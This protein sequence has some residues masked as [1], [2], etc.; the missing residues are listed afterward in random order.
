MAWKPTK[1]RLVLLSLGEEGL[2]GG[3]EPSLLT[4]KLDEFSTDPVP[5]A[6]AM[7][8]RPLDAVASAL[9]I[10]TLRVL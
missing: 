2:V 6:I 5:Y 8:R 7:T 10:M 4:G 1:V 3:A 9:L